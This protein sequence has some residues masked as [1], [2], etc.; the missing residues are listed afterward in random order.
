MADQHPHDHPG[1]HDPLEHLWRTAEML[2]QFVDR[3]QSELS[4]VYGERARVWA[5]LVAQGVEQK[6]IADRAGV[7]P[8]D[9]SRALSE[10]NL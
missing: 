3:A 10:R 7:D 4:Q 9:V 2:D 5:A 1:H 8:S 6:E